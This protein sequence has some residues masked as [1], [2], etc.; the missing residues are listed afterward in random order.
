MA[1]IYH[2]GVLKETQTFTDESKIYYGDYYMLANDLIHHTL[3]LYDRVLTDDEVI[4]VS[5]EM[6]V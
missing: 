3:I 4:T 2:N 5:N 1:K 6:G